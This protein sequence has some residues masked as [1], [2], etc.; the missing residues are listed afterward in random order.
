MPVPTFHRAA[1]RHALAVLCLLF[2]A[3]TGARAA[4]N[5]EIELTPRR[6]SEHV[7]YFQGE[8]GMASTA[9]KGFMS[10]AGFVVT[11]DQVVVFDALGSVPLGEAM[12]AAIHK[13]TPLPITL[14][15]V[16]H[17][18]ADHFYGLQAFKAVGAE[19]WAHENA[20]AYLASPLAEERLAQRRRDLFPW[21]DEA[22]RLVPP[23]RYLEGDLKFSRGG[24]DFT[25]LDVHGAHSEDDIMMQV[26][27]D[28]VLF[29]GDLFFAGRIPY[30]GDANTRN[31]LAA[32][33]K[34]LAR[35]P[36]LVIPGHGQASGN[37]RPDIELTRDY[38]RDLRTWM[39]RAVA[40]M[41]PFEEAYAATDWRRYADLPA[42]AAANRLNASRVYTEMEAESLNPPE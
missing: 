19:V 27:P 10:N 7:W 26:E 37:P 24:L 33:D 36:R 42:F 20:K 22:T 25:I 34:M 13:I 16:S 40:D 38:L 12:I 41:Q 31:W 3:L 1:G 35:A 23:D 39:G 32:L 18:H 30:V 4:Q 11:A 5:T 17:Y 8:S 14:V 9:N 21:V 28:G 15:V 2:C 29:A 6:A